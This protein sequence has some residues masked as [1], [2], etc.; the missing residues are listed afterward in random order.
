MWSVQV[1]GRRTDGQTSWCTDRQSVLYSYMWLLLDIIYTSYVCL[2]VLCCGQGATLS[3]D[4]SHSPLAV[5]SGTRPRKGGSIPWIHMPFSSWDVV[6]SDDHCRT[7]MVTQ[8]YTLPF[9][10]AV[11]HSLTFSLTRRSGLISTKWTLAA[12][13]FYTK[14]PPTTTP[15]M[16]FCTFSYFNVCTPKNVCFV[17]QLSVCDTAHRH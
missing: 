12:S 6:N 13:P 10:S 9:A 5:G 8:L 3:Y 2:L 16:A 15:S 14:L 1:W 4:R 7:L 17:T 11:V